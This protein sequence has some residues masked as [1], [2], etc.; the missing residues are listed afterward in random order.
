MKCPNCKKEIKI[1][2]HSNKCKCGARIKVLS[3]KK[4]L[5]FQNF[6]TA[7]ID[8]TLTGKTESIC[9]GRQKLRNKG[10]VSLEGKSL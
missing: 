6:K 3:E 9:N 7:T 4:F 5:K 10:D 2:K 1:L 8:N